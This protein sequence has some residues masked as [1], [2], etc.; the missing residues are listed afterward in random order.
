MKKENLI[1]IISVGNTDYFS[2]K[3]E[4]LCKRY[5]HH[6]SKSEIVTYKFKEL[7]EDIQKQVI[8]KNTD[9][10]VNFDWWDYTIQN[11]KEKLSSIGFD[12]ADIRWSGFWSQG[13]GASFTAYCDSE[14]IINS[15]FLEE[16]GGIAWLNKKNL[17]D[18]AQ[19]EIKRWRLWFEL[20]E[21]GLIKFDMN[22]ISSYYVHENTVEGVLHEDFSGL[23]NNMW[24]PPNPEKPYEFTS[25]FEKKCQLKLLETMFDDLCKDLSREIYRSLKEEYDYL[26]SDDC[27]KEY[28]ENQ[29]TEY[30]EWGNETD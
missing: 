14:K 24:Y 30:D 16:E 19:Q 26:T 25:V 12:D 8:A 10:H 23:N 3:V 17:K 22:R 9:I 15:L 11:W 29:D 1:T 4:E 28:L 27:I 20:A 7:P 13:D 21:N 5:G 2:K 6:F 18:K